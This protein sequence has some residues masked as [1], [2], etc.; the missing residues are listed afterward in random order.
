ML[1]AA[2]AVLSDYEGET[3]GF[4]SH[5]LF[6]CHISFVSVRSVL[7]VYHA[8]GQTQDVDPISGYCWPTIYEAEPTLAQYWV[9]MSCLTPR[10]MW[11]S[12]TDSGPTLT[13]L[14]FKASCGYY[15]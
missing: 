11:A 1:I 7:S 4:T 2:T 6:L 15:S 10:C 13:Q 14:L 3:Y 12:V 8:G 9:T 5:R